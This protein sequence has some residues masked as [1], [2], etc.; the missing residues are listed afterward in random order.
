MREGGVEAVLG[1]G[2]C[3]GWKVHTYAYMYMYEYPW[4]TVYVVDNT[5]CMESLCPACVV[6]CCQAQTI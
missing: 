2:L 6:A 5:V 1:L 3:S 4:C